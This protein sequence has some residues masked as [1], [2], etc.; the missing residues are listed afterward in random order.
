MG[1]RVQDS[2]LEKHWIFSGLRRTSN[3]A[4]ALTKKA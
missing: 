2:N 3:A 1:E 4:H